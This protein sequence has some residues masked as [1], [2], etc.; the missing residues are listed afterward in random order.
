MKPDQ[1]AE[2]IL[3]LKYRVLNTIN[4]R[5]RCFIADIDPIEFAKRMPPQPCFFNI[6]DDYK[7]K[8]VSESKIRKIKPTPPRYDDVYFEG[9]QDLFE[10]DR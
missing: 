9:V 7:P 4:Q 5:P 6:V 1:I 10:E 8:S 2:S 3:S